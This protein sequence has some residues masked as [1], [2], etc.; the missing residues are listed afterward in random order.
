[1]SYLSKQVF[2]FVFLIGVVGSFL[3]AW[4]NGDREI[5]ALRALQGQEDYH[6][7]QEPI[8]VEIVDGKT[9]VVKRYSEFF[10]NVKINTWEERIPVNETRR[11]DDQR[12]QEK[13]R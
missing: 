3:M 13:K 4:S 2:A 5:E 7:E 10:R 1:M 11:E 12:S 6:T 9:Y 8:I